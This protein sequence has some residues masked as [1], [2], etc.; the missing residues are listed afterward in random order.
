[1]NKKPFDVL[2]RH[3]LL[4]L[5]PHCSKELNE[6]YRRSRGIGFFVGRNNVFFCPHCQKVLGVGQSRML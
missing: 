3:D 2:E 1:M 4:P 6:V 5:C